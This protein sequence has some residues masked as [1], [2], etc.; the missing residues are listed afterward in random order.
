M[1]LA[2][3]FHYSLKNREFKPENV[4]C[5]EGDR[6]SFSSYVKYAK[7]WISM[8]LLFYCVAIQWLSL[9]ASIIAPVMLQLHGNSLINQ[10]AHPSRYQMGKMPLLAGEWR[11]WGEKN[12]L[13]VKLNIFKVYLC[14]WKKK[15]KALI[16][17]TSL[18]RKH[19]ALWRDCLFYPLSVLQQW[20][21]KELKGLCWAWVSISLLL[22]SVLI[23]KTCER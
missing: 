12:P 23:Y 21:S 14:V 19:R 11:R 5:S 13:G 15:K 10:T 17:P 6:W 8:Q 4:K 2:C 1:L 18:G 22:F 3:Y 9:C 20:S 7:L 16:K